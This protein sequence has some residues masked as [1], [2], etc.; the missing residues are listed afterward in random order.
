MDWRTRA[1]D[2]N[3]LQ[4]VRDEGFLHALIDAAGFKKSD[5]VLCAG[6]GTGIA[7]R[8]FVPLVHR[9]IGLD[10]SEAMLQRGAWE[11]IS[12]VH[13]DLCDP[14]FV[15]ARF[16]KIVLRLVL[17]HI[18]N[19]SVALHQCYSI[20]HPEG[21]IVVAEGI[22]PSDNAEVVSWFTEMFKLKEER[23]VFTPGSLTHLLSVCGF[24]DL[25]LHD[26]IMKDFSVV[27]WLKNSGL[28]HARQIEIYG[29]HLEAP[30]R[31]KVAYNMRTTGNDCLID[32]HNLII[33][34]G[35]L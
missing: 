34:G 21:R 12:V 13:W 14:L 2:Y 15:D 24:G 23:I 29:V 22:P 7:A 18:S 20:L 5:T 25:K 17:H 27:N 16:D 11:G 6:A 26:Y 3:N 19:P 8:C 9:I 30:P 28:D 31:V 1:I 4:W 33:T 32:V 10:S 35:K